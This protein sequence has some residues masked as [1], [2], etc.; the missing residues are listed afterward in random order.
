MNEFNIFFKKCVFFQ[1]HFTNEKLVLDILKKKGFMSS[2]LYLE[3]LQTI[4]NVN[5][6]E[7]LNILLTINCTFV[8]PF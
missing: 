6:H 1:I 4:N 5:L 8:H 2:L 3:Y 7:V